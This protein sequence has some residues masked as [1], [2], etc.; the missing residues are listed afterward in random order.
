MSPKYEK[1]KRIMIFERKLIP[2]DG[3]KDC[4]LNGE[5]K[6][7]FGKLIECGCDEC[8]YLLCCTNGSNREDC[9]R[10]DDPFCPILAKKGGF[11]A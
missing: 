4:P 1:E 7:I 10:C 11:F 2:G 6:N 3:G 8:D 9:G 5:R